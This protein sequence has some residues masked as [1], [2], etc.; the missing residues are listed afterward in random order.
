MTSIVQLAL[1]ASIYDFIVNNQ[2][3]HTVPEGRILIH[4]RESLLFYFAVVCSGSWQ[5]LQLWKSV[6]LT[7]ENSKTA[8][9][10]IRDYLTENVREFFLKEC[11]HFFPRSFRRDAMLESGLRFLPFLLV[12]NAT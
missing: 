8:A 10:A 12:H 3:F 1:I 5:F 6:A 4:N 9:A 2:K 11:F 7:A